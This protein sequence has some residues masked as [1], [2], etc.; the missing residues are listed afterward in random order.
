MTVESKHHLSSP[1]LGT[2]SAAAALGITPQHLRRLRND[3]LLKPGK[4]YKN[5]ARPGAARQT[6]RWHLTHCSQALDVAAEKR[7]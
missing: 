5:I 3:G 7:R 4:H 6:Y 2:S 1:W